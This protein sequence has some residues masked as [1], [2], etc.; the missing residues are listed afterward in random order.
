MKRL[1][2]AAIA[3]AIVWFA[4]PAS[5]QT[6]PPATAFDSGAA[7]VVKT[8]EGVRPI[9]LLPGLACG[10]YVFAGI[11]PELAAGHPVYALTFAGF[12]G[13]AP[14]N[15]PYLDAYEKSVVALI[16]REHLVKPILIGHSLGGHLAVRIAEN[17]PGL[18]GAVIAVDSLPLFPLPQPGETPETRHTAA[19]RFRQ[20]IAAEPAQTFAQQAR[21]Q[22]AALVTAPNDVDLVVDHELRG[23]QVTIGGAGAEMM[24]EDLGPHLTAITA[25]LLVIA[26]APDAATAPQWKAGYAQLYAGVRD[27]TVV[28]IAPA[29]HFVMLDQP[30]Q[31]RS[32]VDGFLAGK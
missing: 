5:A 32:A 8:G 30:A 27:L 31:F 23:D 20:M 19:E 24:D 25:P 12:D 13:V 14:V 11:I 17:H 21:L 29:K 9:I 26:A 4:T 10:P 18:V 28:T 6:A 3:S 15:P 2:C 22:I 16:E 7:H 1:L